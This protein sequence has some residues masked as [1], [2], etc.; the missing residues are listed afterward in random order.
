MEDKPY[1]ELVGGLIYLASATRPDLSFTASVLSRF[2][3]RPGIAHWQ[4]AKRVLRYIKGTMDYG[5]TYE[6]NNN[7][8]C[9]YVDAD[10]RNDIDD[11]RSYTGNVIILAKDQLVGRQRSRDQWH[12]GHI[13]VHH[14]SRVHGLIR[15]HK[16]YDLFE[17]TITPHE[18]Y[19]LFR[20]VYYYI[21]R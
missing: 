18:I 21:L 17:R 10:W 6:K 13:S 9:A 1:R 4:L 3:S 14:G 5:I 19:R 8:M 20:Q 11:R 2:C 15:N 12:Y 16:G 7:N